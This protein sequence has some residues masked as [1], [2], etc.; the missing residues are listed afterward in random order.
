MTGWP[1]GVLQAYLVG[2]ANK[3]GCLDKV[4]CGLRRAASGAQH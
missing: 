1:D 2:F 3:R 4:D